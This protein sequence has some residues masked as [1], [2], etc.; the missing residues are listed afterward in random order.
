VRA[1]INLL[2]GLVFVVG[3]PAVLFVDSAL[4]YARDGEAWVDSARSAGLREA[5]VDANAALVVGEVGRD[6]GLAA[7]DRVFVRAGID[8]VLSREWFDGTVRS[9]HAAAVSGARGAS[10]TAAVDLGEFK[11]ALEVRLGLVGE[12]ATDTCRELFGAQP[13]SD[14]GRAQQLIAAYRQRAGRAIARV[15]DRL[16]LWP[17]AGGGENLDRLSS[18]RGTSLILVLA[19]VLALAVL[20]WRRPRVLGGVLATGAAAFLVLGLVLRFGASGPIGRFL[21]HR[22]GIDEGGDQPVAIAARGLHRFAG[23]IVADATRAGMIFA[24]MLAVVGIALIVVARA[25]ERR[26]R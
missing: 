19:S 23:Q 8:H 16:L 13:C 12:R 5:L 2:A 7:L 22:A 10:R 20:N 17:D 21:L 4:R 26:S 6:P 11:R 3:F 24:A 15:P 14:Q 18:L 1:L 9:V 25:R